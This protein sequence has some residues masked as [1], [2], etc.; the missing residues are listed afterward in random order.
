[1]NIVKKT[2]AMT[3]VALAASLSLTAFAADT[4]PKAAK[5]ELPAPTPARAYS[6]AQMLEL[7]KHKESAQ[8]QGFCNGFGQGVYDT[9]LVMT[10]NQKTPPSRICVKQPAP[11]RQQVLD[12]YVAWADQHPQY[13]DMP[14]AE[15][16]L[17]FLEERFPC[18][19]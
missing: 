16:A 1:M 7:C 6:M 12:D 2:A 3:A 10:H 5:Q 9:Y 19:K 4:A 11:Q 8:V 13:K 15:A 18:T 17:R 14:A